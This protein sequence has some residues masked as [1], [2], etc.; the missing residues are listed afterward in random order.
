MNQVYEMRAKQ[1]IISR[2]I[3]PEWRVIKDTLDGEGILEVY[4]YNGTQKY[5]FKGVEGKNYFRN[6]RKW[7]EFGDFSE[8]WQEFLLNCTI[9]EERLGILYAIR[10][11]KDDE[12]QK[13]LKEFT[14]NYDEYDIVISDGMGGT[15]TEDY[16]CFEISNLHRDLLDAEERCFSYYLSITKDDSIQI[17]DSIRRRQ[18]EYADFH[19][20]KIN[21]FIDHEVSSTLNE[22]GEEV[23]EFTE[24]QLA[25]FEVLKNLRETTDF[26]FRHQLYRFD[27]KQQQE[28]GEN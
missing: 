1:Y 5:V 6:G 24:E 15:Q 25:V 13:C 28:Q 20:R 19:T 17:E 23:Y 14:K 27:Q 16:E 22:A 7:K 8:A 26:A 2:G 21:E 12:Y 11:K 3:T 4:V 10:D 18:A 9:G